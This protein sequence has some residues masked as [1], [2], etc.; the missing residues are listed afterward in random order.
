MKLF[1]VDLRQDVDPAQL[2]WPSRSELRGEEAAPA[3]NQHYQDLRG[4]KWEDVARV[5]PFEHQL[6]A[7]LEAATDAAAEEERIID[8]LALQS[9]ADETHPLFELDIGVASAVLTLSSGGAIPATSC[10]GGAFGSF[11]QG[12]NPYVAFYVRPRRLLAI[13]SWAK[14]AGLGLN[15]VEG[16]VGLHARRV[17]D[18]LTFAE[19][20]LAAQNQGG[21]LGAV[22]ELQSDD[23]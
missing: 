18:L 2:Y 7:R 22:S 19:V 4:F 11:H 17:D 3:G 8:E 1:N 23:T 9:E 5:L 12:S 20:A 15:I 21:R 10:N 13:Q 14:A 16:I 6:L